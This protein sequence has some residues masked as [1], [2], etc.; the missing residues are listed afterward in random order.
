MNVIVTGGAGFVGSTLVGKLLDWIDYNKY[1]IEECFPITDGVVT[2][3]D[4]RDYR[5]VDKLVVVDSLVFNQNSLG[6]YMADD[7]FEFIHGDVTD[8]SLM[9]P[10]YEEA[11]VIIPLSAI[12]GFPACAK[13]PELAWKINYKSVV[14]MLN[15][16]GNNKLIV[17]PCT[18][19]G[20][21]VYPDGRYVTE[22]DPLNP[23]SVYGKSKVAAE[24]E[25]LQNLGVSL[26][27]ATVM[28][29]SYFMRVGLLVNTFCWQAA[30]H[31]NIVLYQKQNKRNYIHVEDAC[32]AFLLAIEKY[33]QMKGQAYNVG[34]S[35]ANINK[36]QLAQ[37]IAKYTELHIL[38]A[39]LME[40]PDRR[41]Y[42]VS[43]A[44]I[45]ALGFKPTWTLDATIKQLLKFY[46]SISE[47]SA[48]VY[49]GTT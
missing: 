18:N 19:S 22:E 45:E 31:R 48:N 38:E 12:V 36:E 47:H 46:G 9:K 26:R 11:D 20:Y 33:D 14:E 1:G 34:L 7:R 21:G 6:Q 24:K 25:V 16:V 29:W 39:P 41:D 43:N 23:I 42:L 13:H 27:L 49:F 10:L 2:H 17:F 32:Q 8:F 30:R 35:T 37:K 28:G 4:L 3:L 40:D 5:V 15:Y 44:K